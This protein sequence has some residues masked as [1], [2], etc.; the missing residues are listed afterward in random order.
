MTKN[1]HIFY[2]NE[3]IKNLKNIF[4]IFY[5]NRNILKLTKNFLAIYENENI[6]K[7]RI[8]KII[9]YE[10]ENIIFMSS[11][12]AIKN[13]ENYFHKIFCMKNFFM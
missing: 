4:M 13:F 2:E 9:I 7:V 12:I 5:E 1:L 3:N 11:K 10:N 8:K 6:Q